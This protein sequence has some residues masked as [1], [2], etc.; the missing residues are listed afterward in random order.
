MAAPPG[1][2]VTL[3]PVPSRAA[4]HLA[5]AARRHLAALEAT[6]NL[7]H[8]AGEFRAVVDNLDAAANSG[9]YH[10]LMVDDEETCTCNL[11]VSEAAVVAHVS[12]RS[13]RRRLADGALPSIRD[14]RAYL[15]PAAGLAEWIRAGRPSGRQ[16]A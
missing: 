3:I 15:V 5:L 2:A 12:A 8:A 10:H 4:A 6:P 13:L 11:R 1:R 9:Q 14:G 7:G 16:A